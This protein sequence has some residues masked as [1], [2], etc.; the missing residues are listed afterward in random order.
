[1]TRYSVI[2]AFM[3]TIRL[4]GSFGDQYDP[5]YDDSILPTNTAEHQ[6]TANK[7]LVI[8]QW[9]TKIGSELWSDMMT[10]RNLCR[11]IKYTLS[12]CE[13]LYQLINL[14]TE[15]YW[16]HQPTCKSQPKMFNL[17]ASKGHDLSLSDHVFVLSDKIV[18]R[19]LPLVIWTREKNYIR[20]FNNCDF[21][22]T[23]QI[24]LRGKT[25][26]SRLKTRG[27]PI[28]AELRRCQTKPLLE[29]NLVTLAIPWC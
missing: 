15:I 10:R 14:V 5:K 12:T 4:T 11:R 19:A 25:F 24:V 9:L 18:T 7:K 22:T 23:T 13:M 29:F 6:T 16:S 8:G 3:P 2:S 28:W 1:M 20:S 21:M 27:S 17:H 26:K